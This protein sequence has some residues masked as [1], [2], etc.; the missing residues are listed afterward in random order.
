MNTSILDT[1]TAAFVGV[2]QAGT[3]ALAA[4]SLPALQE[5]VAGNL[6]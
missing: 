5:Q 6:L 2:L 3:A 1:I 4:F